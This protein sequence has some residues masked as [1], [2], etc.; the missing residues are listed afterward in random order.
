M[1]VLDLQEITRQYYQWWIMMEDEVAHY[2]IPPSLPFAGAL[3][4]D[5]DFRSYDYEKGFPPSCYPRM[6]RM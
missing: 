6:E 4:T 2:V 3:G 1:N 5:E